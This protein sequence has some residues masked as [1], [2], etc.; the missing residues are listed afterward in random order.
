MGPRL[1]SCIGVLVVVVASSASAI[2]QSSVPACGPPP[3]VAANSQPNI[4]SEEQEQW[5]GDAM[6]DMLERDYR[7]PRDPSQSAYLQKIVDKLSATLPDTHIKFLALMVD[8]SEANG[9][10]MAGG[11]IYLT[12]KLAAAAQNDDELAAVLGHEMG[13]IASHQFAFETTRDLK[14]LLGIA[15]V[16]DRADIY[17]KFQKLMDA[18]IKDKH[19]GK[20]GDSEDGQDEADRIGVYVT[21]AAGYSP[22][23][24][25]QLWN[26]ITFAEGKTGGRFSDFF[27][28]T[29]PNEKRLRGMMKMN[30]ALPP[31]CGVKL[32]VSGDAFAQ[33]HRGVVANQAVEATVV[34]AGEKTVRLTPPLHM[35]L[36]RLRFSPD[37]KTILAQDEGSVFTITREPYAVQFRFDAENALPAQFSPDSQNIVFATPGLH[38]EEWSVADK[39]MVV[40]HEPLSRHTC[41]E[42]KLSPDGR[43]VICVTLNEEHWEMMLTLLDSDTGAVVWEKKDFFKPTYLAVLMMWYS[44]GVGPTAEWLP[45][46]FSADGNTL[47]I[48]PDDSKLAFDLRTRTPIKIGGD[49]RNNKISGSYAFIGNDEIVGVNG[50]DAKNSGIFSFPDGKQLRKMALPASA[51][52]SVAGPGGKE[53]VLMTG[54]TDS[55]IA[56]GD[57]ETGK[58]LLRSKTAPLDSWNGYV[59]SE[60]TDGSVSLAKMQESCLG[61]KHSL[62]LPLS[63]LGTLRSVAVS[64]DGKHIALST[65][66]RGGVWELA[67]GNQEFLLNGFTNAVWADDDSMYA[68]F[69]KIGK[70]ERHVGHFVVSS[71]ASK[72]LTYAIDDKV[73]MDFGQLTEWK[74]LKKG[75]WE[76]TVH[77][78]TDA[79]VLWTKTFPDSAPRY[80]ESYGGRELL[81]TSLLRLNSVKAL[82][83]ENETLAAEAAA[84][85]MKENGRL[86]EVVDR[87]TGKTVTQMVL[88]LPLNFNGTDGLNRAGDLLYMTSSDN[89]T[90]VYSLT[91][92]KQLRQIFG[93]VVAIDPDS[94]RVCTLNRRDEAAVYDSNGKDLAHFRSGSTVRQASFREHGTQ[95]ILL[96]ADQTVKTV[97]VANEDSTTALAVQ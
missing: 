13:H 93:H 85:K 50:R 46:T 80:T 25:A 8:S 55:A 20:S 76:L 29:K 96:T 1:L 70:T 43:T 78:L 26:R 87:T 66:N 64:P 38:S 65:R 63:P 94:Q 73:H 71:R 21:A 79:S 62:T 97:G 89:R 11:H 68:E 34:I 59:L 84:V 61:E 60:N 16:G 48:G 35:D 32:P 23:G 3:V 30:A 58:F 22:E 31:G 83:K 77:N 15:S 81:F 45:S 27:G 6:A 75:G 14:R 86:V 10:S 90:V 72:I 47:L 18:R 52:A 19:P 57:L 54:L 51:L 12:R 40:A 91:T 53:Y 44:H 92:G 49:L 24:G 39:K 74:Q 37:G 9:F 95:L 33:W 56:L 2:A 4:F 67:T 42:S 36:E 28:M 82:L 5:L 41:L 17:E 69:P 88:E 7:P